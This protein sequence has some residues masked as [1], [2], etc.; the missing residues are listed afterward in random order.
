MMAM[1]PIVTGGYKPIPPTGDRVE[2]VVEPMRYALPARL[3]TGLR[4]IVTPSLIERAVDGVGFAPVRFSI[5][6]LKTMEDGKL[7]V[8]HHYHNETRMGRADVFDEQGN[9]LRCYRHPE[10]G[11]NPMTFKSGFAFTIETREDDQKVFVPYEVEFSGGWPAGSES[12]DLRTTE[13]ES[14]IQGGINES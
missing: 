7:L 2:A 14:R 6:G 8:P 11:L 4:N 12:R 13:A 3:P 9:D 5:S 1:Q 10:N